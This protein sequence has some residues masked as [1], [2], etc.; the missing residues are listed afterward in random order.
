[1][2]KCSNYSNSLDTRS[3]YTQVSHLIASPLPILQNTLWWVIKKGNLEFTSVK[4]VSWE[5]FHFNLPTFQTTGW[6]FKKKETK[7]KLNRVWE[8][9]IQDLKYFLRMK[10]FSASCKWI[11]II[12]WW[13]PR[14]KVG[15]IIRNSFS[16][17]WEKFW[18]KPE[19]SGCGWRTQ[20]GISHY[21][22]P[23]FI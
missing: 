8:I 12:Q 11:L 21:L 10:N 1:M 6:R 9:S 5:S 7:Q 19:N 16:E 18:K 14:L 13:Q 22:K 2:Q 20:K 23:G 3:I 4:K 15:M 17:S